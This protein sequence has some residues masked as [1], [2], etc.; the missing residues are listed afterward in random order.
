MKMQCPGSPGCILDILKDNTTPWDIKTLYF[1]NHDV[2]QRVARTCGLFGEL[3]F[4]DMESTLKIII[5]NI[6]ICS[7]GQDSVT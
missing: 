3:W 1:E 5:M 4:A 6:E 2:G 7:F